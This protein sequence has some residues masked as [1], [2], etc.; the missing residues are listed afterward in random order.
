MANHNKIL[1]TGACGLI[2]REVV[3]QLVN[4]GYTDITA[5]D[6]EW[7]YQGVNLGPVKFINS[8]LIDFLQSTPNTF[9]TVY[10]LSAINGT[11]YFYSIPNQLIE[12]N[13]MSDLTLFQWAKTGQAK[14][15][16]ASSSEVVADSDVIPTPEEL[17]VTIRN[18]HNPRWS[19]RLGKIISENYLANS[20]LDYLIIRFFNT[21]SEHTASG[22][23]VRDL[24]EKIQNQNFLVTGAD[25]TRSFCYVQD[26]V[27]AVV[28]LAKTTS[29][30]VVNVGSDEELKIQQV[31]DILAESQGHTNV[32][33]K[34]TP[35]PEGSVKRRRPDITKLRQLVK[36]FN[37]ESFQSVIKKIKNCLTTT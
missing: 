14:I 28:E 19:Y 17:D 22:H 4:Q 35:G 6:N 26:A 13:V 10:H 8:S 1:V 25:E 9:D 27:S 7:K 37:P 29:C 21:Y 31:A 20:E 18:I 34:L 16:Y 12:N 23:V 33:W 36:T 3:R 11:K 15:V 30:T 32:E 24:I 5:V 2:G